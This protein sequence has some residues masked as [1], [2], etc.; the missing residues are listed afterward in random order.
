MGDANPIRTLGDYSKPSHEG[1]M[2]PLNS[3]K[4]IMWYLFDPTPFSWCKMDAHSADFG[5]ITTWEDLTTH[6]LAQFFPSRRTYSKK[7]LI[8]ASTFGSKS[9]SFM[10]ASLPPQ[11]ETINQSTGG[12][13]RDKNAELSW[14]LLEE[15][16]LYDNEIW[17][18]PRDFSI[19][20]KT[21]SL[22]QD[23]SS[24]SDC[25]LIEL[26]HQV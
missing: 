15:L 21:I 4:G 14:A 2:T 13:L 8:R 11:D 23:V 3:P 17:N 26:K 12:K 18:D 22:P 1:Y 16:A 6:F 5:S 7:S 10:T 24:T 9:K 25:R 19:P 20:I